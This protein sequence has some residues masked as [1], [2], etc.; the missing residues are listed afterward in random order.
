MKYFVMSVLLVGPLV[1]TLGLR[2]HDSVEPKPKF[3]RLAN[4]ARVI[5][6]RMKLNENRWPGVEKPIPEF[7]EKDIPYRP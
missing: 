5:D 6:I 1:L 2:S 3:D 7:K 4:M